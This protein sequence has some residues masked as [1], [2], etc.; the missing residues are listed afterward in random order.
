VSSSAGLLLGLRQSADDVSGKTRRVT[1]TPRVAAKLGM[2]V[3]LG[4]SIHA[5]STHSARR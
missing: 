5:P 3:E 4:F 2:A 1:G